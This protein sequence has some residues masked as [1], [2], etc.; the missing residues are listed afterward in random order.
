MKIVIVGGIAGGLSAASQIKREDH[1]AQ[2]IVLEKS[3]DVSY[4]AC[5]MPY[6]LFYK[7]KPVEDLYALNLDAIQNERGIDYRQHQEA[8]GIAPV[9]KEVKVVDH[10][11]A[12]EYRES[13]D[14]LVYA[15]GNKPIKLPLPGFD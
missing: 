8:I 12:R 11:N 6:N 2:V 1:G 15:T 14:Y 9:R 10:I 3:G 7:D 13:Y 5:G 4:A